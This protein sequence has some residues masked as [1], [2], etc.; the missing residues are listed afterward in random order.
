MNTVN[1]YE[2]T[3]MLYDYDNR[4]NLTADIEF[5]KEYAKKTG[6]NVLEL[7]CGTGRVA[8]TLAEVGI[9]VTGV[10]LS[11]SMLEMFNEKLSTTNKELA[12]KITLVKGNMADFKLNK[13][14]GLIIAPFRAFQALTEDGDIKG[15]IN[16]ITEHLTEDGLFI[17]NVFRPYKVLDE[18]WC[19]EETIQWERIDE[20]SGS[21]IVKKHWGDKI[22]TENQIIYP[23]YGF[24][25]TD[26]DGKFQRIEDH[27]KLKYYYADQLKDYLK[28]GGL[29]IVEEYGWY[30]KSSIENGR[31]LIYVCKRK[32]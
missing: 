31:E 2:N 22:D 1:T 15:S 23:H 6:S 5:Y 8:L 7:G 25:I 17:I 19:Y 16:C 27:L 11:D 18:S 3:A 28:M 20:K 10:D 13:N 30:D 12:D 4:D 14:F 29:T 24:E 26:S 9:N 21:K 32:V